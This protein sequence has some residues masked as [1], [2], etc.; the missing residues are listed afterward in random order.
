MRI[1]IN[2]SWKN[3]KSLNFTHLR[4]KLLDGTKTQTCRT[5]FIANY[6]LRETIAITSTEVTEEKELLFLVPVNKHYPKR[7][8]D[9]SLAEAKKDG[10][11]TKEDF[12]EKLLEINKLKFK[13]HW[14]LLTAWD[15]EER[16][17]LKDL[18]SFAAN[19]AKSSQH[20][21]IFDYI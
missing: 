12:V 9:V 4:D 17:F 11:E 16:V 10:F 2:G 7:L 14:S 18:E 19:T 13:E 21:T 6:Q 20:P 8:C 5:G 3:F 15:P 1:E